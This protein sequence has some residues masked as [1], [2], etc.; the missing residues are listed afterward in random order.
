M[1]AS[2]SKRAPRGVSPAAPAAARGIARRPRKFVQS[3]TT[4]EQG[5][6]EHFARVVAVARMLDDASCLYS[7]PKQNT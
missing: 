7:Y 4:E 1:F 6:P 2:P 3:R 5:M